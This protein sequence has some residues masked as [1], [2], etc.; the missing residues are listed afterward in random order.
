MHDHIRKMSVLLKR[1][2]DRQSPLT[3]VVEELKVCDASILHHLLL[4][5]ACERALYF[6]LRDLRTFTGTRII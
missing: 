6:I 3:K 1:K 2:T 5:R 4:Q